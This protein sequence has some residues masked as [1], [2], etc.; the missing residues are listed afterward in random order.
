TGC[1]K[2]EFFEGDGLQAVR[3]RLKTGPALAAEGTAF[4]P[5]ST[6]FRSLFSPWGMLSSPD[7][8]FSAACQDPCSDRSSRKSRSLQCPSGSSQLNIEKAK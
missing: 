5:Y 1:G 8:T 3:K 7:Q 2:T 4:A 6:F